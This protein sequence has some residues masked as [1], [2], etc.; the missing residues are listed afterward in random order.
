MTEA[1]FSKLPVTLDSYDIGCFDVVADSYGFVALER[2]NFNAT[3]PFITYLYPADQSQFDVYEENGQTFIR[4]LIFFGRNRPMVSY[5]RAFSKINWPGNTD[6]N[7]EKY[8]LK[9]DPQ[10]VDCDM[11]KR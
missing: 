4:Q 3:K 8:I 6:I 2:A 5:W 9:Y 1:K 7:V 11:K 10:Q